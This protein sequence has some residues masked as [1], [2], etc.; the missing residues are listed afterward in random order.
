MDEINDLT[1][2]QQKAFRSLDKAY[3]RC[4]KTGILFENRYGHLHAY[5]GEKVIKLTD[6]LTLEYNPIDNIIS[7]YDAKCEANYFEIAG[8][9]CADDGSHYLELTDYGMRCRDD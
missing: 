9:W 6:D 7:V 4:L 2:V 8:E 3:K 1:V 5:D